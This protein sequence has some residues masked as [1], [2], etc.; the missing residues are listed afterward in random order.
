[1]TPTEDMVRVADEVA[2]QKSETFAE[3]CGRKERHEMLEAALSAA[4]AAMWQD[5][6]IVPREPTPE[7]I[8]AAVPCEA[9]EDY[10]HSAKKIGAAAVLILGGGRNIGEVEGRLVNEA[11]FLVRDYRAMISAAPTQLSTRGSEKT[12][13]GRHSAPT[14]ERD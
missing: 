7:M 11:A 6:V 12:A 10:G 9:Q 5:H 2:C 3:F 4:L 13:E 14:K 1:M 8:A